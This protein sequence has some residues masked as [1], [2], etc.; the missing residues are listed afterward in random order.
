MFISVTYLQSLFLAVTLCFMFGAD[1]CFAQAEKSWQEVAAVDGLTAAD[2]NALDRDQLLLTSGEFRRM[3]EAY[4]RLDLPLFVTSDS[5]LSAYQVLLEESLAQLEV[6]QSSR[7]SAALG[8]ILSDLYSNALTIQ[9]L[10]SLNEKATRRAQLVVGVAARLL[11]SSSR[12]GVPDLDELIAAEC[13]RVEL[14]EGEALPTWFAPPDSSLLTIHYERFKPRSFYTHSPQLERYF[15]AVSW[16]Q[17]IPFRVSNDEELLSILMLGHALRPRP[18][19]SDGMTDDRELWAA[20]NE[21]DRIREVFQYH[22]T[23]AGTPDTLGIVDA[24]EQGDLLEQFRHPEV[25]GLNGQ[26]EQKVTISLDDLRDWRRQLSEQTRWAAQ[27]NDQD[28]L[29]PDDLTLVDDLQFR[30]MPASRTPDSVLFQRTTD[31]RRL[32]R[33]FPSGL[34]VV[35]ALEMDRNR[36]KAEQAEQKRRASQDVEDDQADL[37]PQVSVPQ[38]DFSGARQFFQDAERELV[39]KEID[40]GTVQFQMGSVYG[41][42]LNTLDSLIDEPDSDAPAFMRTTAWQRKSCNTVLSS[43]AQARHA[44]ALHIKV[45]GGAGGGPPPPPAFVEP[46]PE[47][48]SRMADLAELT[49]KEL[50]ASGDLQPPPPDYRPL[51][52]ILQSLVE[53]SNEIPNAVW[54]AQKLREIDKVEFESCNIAFDVLRFVQSEDSSPETFEDKWIR[55]LNRELSNDLIERVRTFAENTKSTKDMYE[56]LDRAEK[57]SDGIEGGLLYS[58]TMLTDKDPDTSIP[59]D[60]RWALVCDRLIP[61]FREQLTGIVLGV[62]NAVAMP[63]RIE[64]RRGW[65]KLMTERRVRSLVFGIA[66]KNLAPSEPFSERWKMT[67]QQLITQA[68]DETAQKHPDLVEMMDT[69]F[70]SDRETW[71]LLIDTSRRLEAIAHKQLR[72]AELNRSEHAFLLNYHRV[73]AELMLQNTYSD[74]DDTPCISSVFTSFRSQRT[75]HAAVSR[76]QAIYVLYPWHGTKYLCRGAV[77]PYREFV[78]ESTITDDEWRELLNSGN[79]PPLPDWLQ[80]IVS[81][82]R[83]P[84]HQD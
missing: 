80:P 61:Q 2:I 77:Q 75:L 53:Y 58:I 63:K 12:T 44:F 24:A 17:T 83:T 69:G 6:S 9:G 31:I 40:S 68:E 46:D 10:E 79:A 21:S 30:V 25:A 5:I 23:F 14:A 45:N 4:S 43:W 74:E 76:P 37:R 57:H 72:G 29:P 41:N 3:N 8:T 78:S 38:T 71:T 49:K 22:H 65:S 59:W 62:E 60:A 32:D 67:V 16:L 82:S 81:P 66:R 11:D 27:I 64:Q 47:F 50:Y 39:L 33:E 48:F 42:W 35:I 7:L 73:V 1:T 26:P 18:A 19:T 15:R 34:E 84:Q 52:P 70:A 13:Q 56:R 51:I 36:R 54:M 20:Q 55:V 28:R